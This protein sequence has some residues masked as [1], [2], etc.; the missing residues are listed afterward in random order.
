MRIGLTIGFRNVLPDLE[1]YVQRAVDAEDDGF[2]S[3]WFGQVHESG[4]DALTLIALA[5]QRTRRI[6]IGTAVLPTY[7][8]HPVVMA[9]QALTAQSAT[10][11]RLTLGIGVS[12]PPRIED[13]LGLSLH[14]PARHMREYLSVL[15]PLVS[16][17]SVGFNGQMF[18]VSGALGVPGARPFPIIVAAAGPMMLRVAGELGEGSMTPGA[19]PK[20]IETFIVPRV[21]GAAAAVGQ[22]KRRICIVA[23]IGVTDDVAAAREQA[24]KILRTGIYHS[25]YKHLLDIEGREEPVD[26][27]IFG[28]EADVER[29]LRAMADAGAT[30]L[31]AGIF[32]VGEDAA[33]SQAR[34]RALLKGLVGKI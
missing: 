24:S 5:G 27:C 31:L 3:V 17:G 18:R 9:Q 28:K 6:E 22:P 34:T 23:T 8:R 25:H 30:D 2:E 10:G 16:E 33:A 20:T 29:Q 14:R 26:A 13:F 15:R 19:G 32:P 11:G 12:D 4:A 21:N 7:P 1:G